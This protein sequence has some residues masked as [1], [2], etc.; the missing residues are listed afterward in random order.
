MKGRRRAEGAHLKR[1]YLVAESVAAGCVL[2][3]LAAQAFGLSSR[4]GESRLGDV[5]LAGGGVAR[6][7]GAREL[8]LAAFPPRD[9]DREV[10]LRRANLVAKLAA[11]AKHALLLLRRARHVR[12]HRRGHHRAVAALVVGR[13]KARARVRSDASAARVARLLDAHLPSPQTRSTRVAVWRGE[14]L[15]KLHSAGVTTT[16]QRARAK[17]IRRAARRPTVPRQFRAK[18]RSGPPVRLFLA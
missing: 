5:R 4:L 2:R 7:L 1:E 18:T 16:R 13:L 17:K 11:E 6:R 8:S 15:W 3:D 14:A 10:V 12:G 9:E